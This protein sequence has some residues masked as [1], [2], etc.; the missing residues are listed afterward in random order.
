M[1]KKFKALN[2]I[3]LGLLI[4]GSNLV[5]AEKL[6][7]H[8]YDLPPNQLVTLK[9]NVLSTKKI[10]CTIRAEGVE[11]SNLLKFVSLHNQNIVNG[12][13]LPEGGQISFWTN[14]GDAMALELEKNS[15]LGVTNTGS[16]LVNIEC[17]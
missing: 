15:E 16:K 9:G 1:S 6:V 14:I 11:N 2:T 5:A 3:A 10:S 7:T 4:G 17:T 8:R 13:I 12:H